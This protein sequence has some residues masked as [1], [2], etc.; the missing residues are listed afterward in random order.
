MQKGRERRNSLRFL[1]PLFSYSIRIMADF[2]LTFLGT[3]TS[4]G[5][6]MIGCHCETCRSDDPRDKRLRCSIHVQTPEK[7]WV[8]DTG[9]D[10]RIQALRA[11]IERLDAAVYTHPHMDH[12]SGFDEL[13]RFTIGDE[14][15]IEIHAMPSCLGM[16]ERMFEYAF[17]GQ[18]RYR[19]YL[20]PLPREI[21]GPFDLGLTRVTPL[22]VLHGKVETI[23]FL[24]ERGG[25][26]I[27]AYIPDCKVI[28]PESLTALEGV[29][30][31]IVDALRRTPHITHHN[32]DE[33]LQVHERLRPRQTW[34]THLTCEILHARDEPTLPA[35]VRL[36]YDGLKLELA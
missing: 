7:H 6:P 26:K 22:P 12:I 2:T 3:G 35:G 27:C 14:D 24:F 28:L 21:E 11:E 36:A 33:A 23:G 32:F 17:N 20:K 1:K 29:E 5:V 18:N 8:V 30:T 13:R 31:L 34:F 4:V 9:P 16:L 19:G 10:F 25:R 15:G